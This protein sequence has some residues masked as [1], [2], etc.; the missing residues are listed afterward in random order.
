[1]ANKIVQSL[2]KITNT[3]IIRSLGKIATERFTCGGTVP[4]P[5]TVKFAH[6]DKDGQWNGVTFPGLQNADFQKIIKSSN[7]A[8]FGKGKETVIDKSYRDAYSLEP[9]KFLTSFQLSECGI[10]GEVR[11]SLVPD[12]L[13]IQAELYKMNI[14]TAP[15]GCFKAHVDTPRSGN[16]FGSLVVCLPSQF[17]GGSLLTRHHDQEVAYDWSSPTSDPVQHVQWAAF[18]SDVEHEILPV[19]SGYRATLTYNLHHCDQLN[20]VPSLE[21]TTTPFY[22]NLKAA[23]GQPHFLRE[24]GVLGF[25]CQHSYVFEEFNSK[26]P[27]F[28]LKGSDRMVMLAAN[29]LGLEVAVKSIFDDNEDGLYKSKRFRYSEIWNYWVIGHDP[30]CV[31]REEKTWKMFL[32]EEMGC[33]NTD[34]ITWCQEF[35]QKAPAIASPSYGNELIADTC[36]M[37]AAILVSVPKWSKR[38][39]L[40]GNDTVNINR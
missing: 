16:M 17:T 33:E 40:Y 24:G 12:V 37:A 19:T 38:S 13:N 29:S 30:T 2:E 27:K 28:L 32:E 21:V 20:P 39:S 6:L 1:M 14:Y 8:S 18:F 4:T 9:E 22:Q 25:A 7:V 31:N 3:Q 35:K 5:R 26:D 34:D 36:Y 15:N 11:M 10:L 23:L